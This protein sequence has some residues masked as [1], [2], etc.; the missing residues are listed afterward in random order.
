MV[1][2][3]PSIDP[4]PVHVPSLSVRELLIEASQDP[5]RVVLRVQ[6]DASQKRLRARDASGCRFHVGEVGRGSSTFSAIAAPPTVRSDPTAKRNGWV[7][8]RTT[9]TCFLDRSL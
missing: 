7:I 4:D 9:A 5:S 6:T 1:V 2:P 8:R 3:L